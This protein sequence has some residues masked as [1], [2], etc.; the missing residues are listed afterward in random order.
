MDNTSIFNSDYM[1]CSIFENMTLYDFYHYRQITKYIYNYSK[2]YNFE[3]IIY[4]LIF[5]YLSNV[6]GNKLELFLEMIKKR[7][8]KLFGPFINQLIWGES[9]HE[10]RM[11]TY[12]DDIGMKD[13]NIYMDCNSIGLHF[14]ENN[15]YESVNRWLWWE[16]EDYNLLNYNNCKIHFITSNYYNTSYFCELLNSSFYYNNDKWKLEY[17]SKL[18]FNKI[19][20]ITFTT[21]DTYDDEIDYESISID[22]LKYNFNLHFYPL[23]SYINNI[24]SKINL[25]VCKDNEFIMFNEHFFSLNTERLTSQQIKIKHFDVYIDF[26]IQPFAIECN[27]EMCS[28]NLMSKHINIYH[29]HA[30]FFIPKNNIAQAIVVKYEDS[31]LFSLYKPLFEKQP[32]TYI[33]Y[34]HFDRCNTYQFPPKDKR[35]Y[36]YYKQM[37]NNNFDE[38]EYILID[39]DLR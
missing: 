36:D 8:V 9:C 24:S 22:S 20:P 19:Q 31:H 11:I 10:L 32:I 3:K 23:Q 39:D 30:C 21:L 4:D 25:I 29:Y 7:K 16:S 33:N 17:N 38:G 27:H 13:N 14:K 28:F 37:F 34:N 35:D 5:K 26:K 1:T 2:I 15:K 12:I 6:F 18:I